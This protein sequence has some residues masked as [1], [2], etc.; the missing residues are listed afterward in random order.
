MKR[1]FFFFVTLW[2]VSMGA[3][4]QKYHYDVTNDGSVNIT[5]AVAVINKI[6]GK[7]NPGDVESGE[8]VDLGLPSGTKWASW[9]VGASKPEEYGHYYAWGETVTK[10][11]YSQSTYQYYQNGSYVDIGSDISGTQ[12]DV[13]TVLWGDDWRMPTK[14]EFQELKNNCT[15]EWTTVNGVNGRK[16]TSKTNG[17]SIF[18][19]A[20]GFWVNG[21]FTAAGSVGYYL[22]ST[23]G[24]RPDYS[25]ELWFSSNNATWDFGNRHLGFS[26]RP[27]RPSK[28]SVPAMAVDLGLPSGTMWASHNV[29]ASS[30]EECG[31]YYAWGE[32]EVKNEYGFETYTHI[33][34][35]ESLCKDIG[36]NIS[37][38]KYDVAHVKWGG[39]WRM[40][41]EDEVNELFDNCFFKWTRYNGVDGG[42]F[43]GP[44]GNSVFLP[45]GGRFNG[46][47]VDWRDGGY[48]W[49][50]TEDTMGE[51]AAVDMCFGQSGVEWYHGA[52]RD[53]GFLVRPV[54]APLPSNIVVAEAIDLGLPS[55]TKWASC[56]VGASK[57]E[58]YGE[59]FAWG[60]TGTKLKYN[61]YTYLFN[62][63]D[64]DW[65]YVPI[66]LG[67]DISGTK[68]DVA[69]MKWGGKWHMPTEYDIEE[70][71][72]YC[73]NEWT[74]LNGVNGRKF[75]SKKNG[76]SIFLPA[77]GCHDYYGLKEVGECG[78]YS[79]S[80][81]YPPEAP[82]DYFSR[83]IYFSS[84]SAYYDGDSHNRANGQSVRPVISE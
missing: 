82:F 43:T 42:L 7:D 49:A 56:N 39:N 73:T 38:T 13:A 52:E 19:P 72:E 10:T 70:L 24:Y 29:G 36:S 64:E 78:Y 20:A 62:E 46:T 83:S 63:E 31:N 41:T 45:A 18:L 17:K 53:F 5:D 55:G 50:G 48:Y 57:P 84:S 8:A 40:P 6:L 26:V 30:P 23:I 54:N 51:C 44:N 34:G 66:S 16:F 2:M 9:N 59:Y 68:Y 80:M 65:G 69:R 12:Y 33:D 74:T 15:S 58:E 67:E 28:I 47:E 61:G 37:G 3:S 35:Y 11:E 4:A 60:E 1:M 76:N 21:D 81:L 77:A 14:D 32:T 22:L 27:V 71:F 75:T 79:S 25:C